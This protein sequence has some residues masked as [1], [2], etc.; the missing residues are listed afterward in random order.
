MSKNNSLKSNSNKYIIEKNKFYRIKSNISGTALIH[1]P[2][3]N[4]DYVEYTINIKTDYGKWN[5]KKS[6]D[7]FYKLNNTLGKLFPE[8]NAFFPPKR[9]FFKNSEKTTKERIK[10]FK[11]YLK[12]MLNKINIFLF[13]EI[14]NFLY[15]EKGI[16]GLFIK[17][18]NMLN[19]GEENYIYCTL[20]EA[21]NKKFNKS[22]YQNISDEE[23]ISCLNFDNYYVAILEYEKKRQISFEWDEPTSVTPNTFVIREFL[24]NLSESIENKTDIIQYF[25]NFLKKPNKWIKLNNNEII[26]LFI[27]FD[28][29]FE[30]VENVNV[31]EN[32][33]QFNRTR[34]YENHVQI[35]N[36]LFN[37]SDKEQKSKTKTIDN[38]DDEEN[39]QT[40][41]PGLFQQ[42]GNYDK[43]LFCAIGSLDLLEK[44]LNTEYNPDY[45]MYINVFK[46]MKIFEF[47]YMKLNNIIKNN[48][49]GNKT[50]VK[51]MKL[52]SLIFS[53]KKLVKYIR[54]IITDDNVYKQYKNY[55][56][57]FSQKY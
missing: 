57:N 33:K 30:E 31:N 1:L 21:F 49:G 28:E 26:E 37:W 24:H 43:N 12:F 15:L 53:D 23:I 41:I 47:N 29:D 42:I 5:F 50:N 10:Y 34:T 35:Q 27:G 38:D 56:N 2:G 20:N 40:R 6:Y 8:I 13:E 11:K 18:Y 3:F 22:N 16:I 55:V 45:E 19:V 25:E 39:E 9:F 4:K 52:L 51:A 7:D 17:K 32:V 14:I 46:S 44:L 54:E 36:S 48:I